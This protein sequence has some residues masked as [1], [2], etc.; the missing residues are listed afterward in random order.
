MKKTLKERNLE[1]FNQRCA[2]YVIGKLLDIQKHHH[3]LSLAKIIHALDLH[4]ISNQLTN[5]ELAK[6]VDS[7]IRLF[8]LLDEETGREGLSYARNERRKRQKKVND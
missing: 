1:K 4:K 5:E 6:H 3:D 7:M 2:Y 8:D